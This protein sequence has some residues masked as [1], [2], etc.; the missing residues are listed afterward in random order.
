MRIGD[1]KCVSEPVL[2]N[3]APTCYWCTL[4]AESEIEMGP[5]IAVSHRERAPLPGVCDL[6]S[7]VTS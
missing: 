2:W 3:C 1:C 6:T 5:A 4:N 7:Y